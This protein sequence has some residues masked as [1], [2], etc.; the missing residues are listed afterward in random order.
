MAKAFGY[1][2]AGRFHRYAVQKSGKYVDVD[3]YE[4]VFDRIRPRDLSAPVLRFRPFPWDTYEYGKPLFED[5]KV[6]GSGLQ[7]GDG[8]ERVQS[9]L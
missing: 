4:Y 9:K 3:Y 8:R 1:T 2:Y 5:E 6:K 7:P